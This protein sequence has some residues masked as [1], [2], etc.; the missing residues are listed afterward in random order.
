M[1]KPTS[2]LTNFNGKRHQLTREDSIKGGKSIGSIFK[3]IRKCSKK[4]PY[5][6][7]CNYIEKS[8]QPEYQGKCFVKNMPP[9]AVKIFKKLQSGK[10]S[11]YNKIGLELLESFMSDN[12]ANVKEKLHHYVKVGQFLYGT[13]M[14]QKISN[15][16]G[17]DFVV[18][19]KREGEELKKE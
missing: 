9:L 14:K 10:E 2:Q 5:F 18:R 13:K 8:K 7:N 15:D 4:C 16:E 1:N 17:S 3:N 11:E 6:E 12:S 19:F